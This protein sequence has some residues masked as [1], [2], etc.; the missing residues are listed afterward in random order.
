MEVTLNHNQYLDWKA[1]NKTLIRIKLENLGVEDTKEFTDELILR[2]GATLFVT[3]NVI[4][5]A[6][7]LENI[8][9]L[10]NILS[11]ITPVDYMEFVKNFDNWIQF[12][13]LKKG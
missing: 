1:G 4:Y 12:F 6:L 11:I 13:S 3:T 9:L 2:V 5:I 7:G 10:G 8:K